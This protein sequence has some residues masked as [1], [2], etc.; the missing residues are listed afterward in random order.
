M[1]DI[2]TYDETIQ[3]I[4]RKNL[5]DIYFTTG[6]VFLKFEKEKLC[7]EFCDKATKLRDGYSNFVRS[8]KKTQKAI[9]ETNEALDIDVVEIAKTT[10]SV[11]CEVAIGV[12]S[13]GG[14]SKGTKIAA[15]VVEVIHSSLK[16]KKEEKLLSKPIS[17]EKEEQTEN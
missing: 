3:I 14:A 2:K 8:V 11:A 1:E 7:K 13:V 10:A 12:A 6:E 15:K 4:R 9:K 17:E 5:I 16:R